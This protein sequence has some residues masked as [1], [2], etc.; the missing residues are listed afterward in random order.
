[1]ESDIVII[2]ASRR[3]N[4]RKGL[5]V[6]FR[7]S[8]YRNISGLFCI[9]IGS[10]VSRNGDYSASKWHENDQ[11]TAW[12]GLGTVEEILLLVE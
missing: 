4:S 12:E 6:T 5:L 3:T 7:V 2:Q 1:M 9:N 10:I 11:F 8:S